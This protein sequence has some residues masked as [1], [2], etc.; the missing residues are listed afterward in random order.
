MVLT[1]MPD[2]SRKNNVDA[3][4]WLDD[5]ESKIHTQEKEM[6]DMVKVCF[7]RIGIRNLLKKINIS[8]WTIKSI[9]GYL[10]CAL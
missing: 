9:R 5:E 2:G 6:E 4:K 10:L 7:S 8:N 3:I 1:D